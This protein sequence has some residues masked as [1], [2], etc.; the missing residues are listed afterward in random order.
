MSQN[1]K[2]PNLVVTQDY[3]E[4]F[5]KADKSFKYQLVFNPTKRQLVPLQSYGDDILDKENLTYAGT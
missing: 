4:N 5:K 3:I 1:L 2:M